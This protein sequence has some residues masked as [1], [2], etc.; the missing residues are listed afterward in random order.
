MKRVASGLI[1]VF[2]LSALLQGSSGFGEDT[3]KSE[4]KAPRGRLPSHYGQIGLS[5]EQKEAIYSIQ[6]KFNPQIDALERQIEVLKEKQGKEIEKV[7]TADQKKQL[8]LA[9][10]AA[11]KKRSDA[12][13]SKP[14]TGN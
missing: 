4:K 5:D 10:E 14:K 9:I 7:L 2:A 3:A 6:A 8:E 11:K 1:L 12:A 13:K